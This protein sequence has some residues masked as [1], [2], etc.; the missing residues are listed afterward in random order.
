MPDPGRPLSILHLEDSPR[1]A[2]MARDRLEEGGIAANIEVVRDRARFEQA[3]EAGEWELIL[4]D[5]NIPGYNGLSAL[6]F[7]REKRPLT[8]VIMLSGSISPEEAVACMKEG[9]TDYLLK[10]HPERLPSAVARAIHEVDERRARMAAEASLREKEERLRL[11]C[12]A[13]GMEAW[14]V[15]LR[16]GKIR[17]SESASRRFGAEGERAD[18]DFSAWL[19]QVHP[20]DRE[21]RQAAFDAMIFEG[22]PYHV[23]YRM[24]LPGGDVGWAAVWGTL[25]RDENGRPARVIG[26]SQEITERKKAQAAT[27]ASLREKEA[28][29]KEIHHRVKNNLQVIA[30]L[31]RLEAR[32]IREP[33]AARAVLAMTGRVHS[34]GLLHEMLYRSPTLDDVRLDVY[35]GQIVNSAIRAASSASRGVT[36]ALEGDPVEISI[37]Q[38]APCGLIVHELVSN[39]LRHGFA[40]GRRLAI[41]LEVTRSPKDRI[42]VRVSDNGLGLPR[43]FE[44]RRQNSLGLQLVS[45]LARQ[46]GGGLD[47]ESR[48]EGASF[49]VT[50]RR[51]PPRPWREAGGPPG[52]ANM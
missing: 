25:Q 18:D 39:C 22:R 24:R 34:M 4:C 50:F 40:E 2:A 5:Y 13:A 27:L 44:E 41:T 7:A 1:D 52:R 42:R 32:R 12:A 51:S 26:V 21:R 10:Q 11:A 38:A 16:T 8:P 15:D 33:D 3:I 49:R 19:E 47:I 17:M 46:L 48:A 35:L 6:R 43:N 14:D 28:L 31:V 37:D 9:A 23:E 20:D 36:M 45:D 29:L 30:S